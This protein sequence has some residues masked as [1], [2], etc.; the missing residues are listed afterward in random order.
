MNNKKYKILIITLTIIASTIITFIRGQYDIFSIIGG[1]IAIILGPYIIASLIR[2]GL[3]LS[4]WNF[5]FDDKSFLRT[6]IVIWCIQILL[7]IIGATS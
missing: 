6:F 4:L 1:S 7:N 5:N 3:K 2:Y